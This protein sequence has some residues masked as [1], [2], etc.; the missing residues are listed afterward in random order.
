MADDLKNALEPGSCH[1]VQQLFG[2]GIPVAQMGGA[3]D[4]F[5]IFIGILYLDAHQFIHKVVEP[6]A[7][8]GIQQQ[9]EL[10]Q[11]I[12]HIIHEFQRAAIGILCHVRRL[13]G[14]VHM[15]ERFLDA[16]KALRH[17]GQHRLHDGRKQS[18]LVLE[19]DIDGIGAGIRCRCNDP[20]GCIGIAFV[21][22]FRLCAVQDALGNTFDLFCHLP[23]LF[24]NVVS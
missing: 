17:L 24:H 1:D 11:V 13:C 12:V 10:V 2:Q 15:T 4:R 6:G 14:P 7:I 3:A 9:T 23:F 8:G 21:Q 18:L 20:Q 16:Q 5:H 22:K 19:A